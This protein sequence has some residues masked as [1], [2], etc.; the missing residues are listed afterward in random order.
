[1]KHSEFYLRMELLQ[2][3]LVAMSTQ[4]EYETG[5]YQKLRT[6]LLSHT[7]LR[8]LT[9]EFIVTCRNKSYF[10]Q[11]IKNKFAHYSERRQFIWK[12]FSPLLNYIEQI[13]SSPSDQ[14][15]KDS[16]EKSGHSFIT[17]QWQKCLERRSSDPEAAITSA[18][19]LLETVLKHVLDNL[20]IEYDHGDD[21]QKLYRKTAKELNLS[22]EQHKEEVFKQILGGMLSAVNGLASLRNRYGDAHGQGIKYIRPSERHAKL[23]VNLAGTMASF[24]YETY[25]KNQDTH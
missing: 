7:E 23:A 11:F 10:W 17:S 4:D 13:D 3:T 16:I 21:L 6:E 15:T 18:R 14:I 1:M 24:I 8:E 12:S 20:S 19:T 5:D 22:P 2:N 25:E 9:P